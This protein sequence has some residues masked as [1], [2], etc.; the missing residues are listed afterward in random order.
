MEQKQEY[1]YYVLCRPG[2]APFYVGKGKGR[3][4]LD[5]TERN[6]YCK[7]VINKY[8]KENIIRS[9]SFVDSEEHAFFMEKRLI[10]VFRHLCGYELTNQTDGGEGTSGY[11]C[12]DW[13]RHHYSRIRKGK[14]SGREGKVNSS[15]HRRKIVQA[16][17]GRKLSEEWKQNISRAGKGRIPW[18][19]GLPCRPEMA[20][21]LTTLAAKNRGKTKSQEA[22]SK[23]KATKKQNNKK[24]G[25]WKL[26]PE[27]CERRSKAI[28]QSWDTGPLSKRRKGG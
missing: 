9:V 12:P 25:G 13:L 1:Y 17:T 15:E 14:P 28:K 3:R 4:Y 24:L 8:G 10:A 20:E 5:D 18:N 6:P 16:N 23:Q 22:I 27:Q 11:V 21:H 7:A 2:G 26:T 19:K